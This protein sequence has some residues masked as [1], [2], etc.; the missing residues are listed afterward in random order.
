MAHV[1]GKIR[2]LSKE[3]GRRIKVISSQREDG[4]DLD[5]TKEHQYF[6]C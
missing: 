3:N 6:K 4:L 2:K 1:R 5:K